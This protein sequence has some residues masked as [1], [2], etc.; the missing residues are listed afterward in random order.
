MG[1]AIALDELL[2]TGWS[3]LDSTGCLFDH[4]GRAYPAV[5]RVQ[6]EFAAA[7][8]ELSLSH[9]A[10]FNVDGA[11]WREA[12]STQAAGS[13]VGNSREEAAVYAL[14]QLRRSLATA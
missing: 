11:E 8:F 13:V 2:S 7:G 3:G 12:G 6:Q 9:N 4:A 14:A 1:I 10:K 5:E